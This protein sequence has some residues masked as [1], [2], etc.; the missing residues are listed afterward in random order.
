VLSQ[1]AEPGQQLN[2]Q[3]ISDL[4]RSFV[5]AL[6]EGLIDIADPS[7]ALGFTGGVSYNLVITEILNTKLKERGAK[8]ITHRRVPNGDGGISFG[9]LVG[10]V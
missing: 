9:Q 10:A 1:H 4:S 3:A 2:N 7:D 8:L 6:F 5:E